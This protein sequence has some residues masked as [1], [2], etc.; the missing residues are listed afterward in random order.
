MDSLS[1]AIP[2][3]VLTGII[4]VIS[5]VGLAKYGDGIAEKTGWGALWVGTILVS[6]ATSLP[7]LITNISAVVIEDSPDL[8]LATVYGSNMMNIFAISIVAIVFGVGNL[9]GGQRRDTQVLVLVALGITTI[10]LAVGAIGDYGLGYTSMGGLVIVLA[11]LGGMKL[12][13]SAGKSET[14]IAGGDESAGV[15]RG[16]ATSAWIGFGAASLAVIVSAPLLAASA[17]GIADATS[18][19]ESFVGVLAVSIVTSLPE[20]AVTFTAARRKSY[21][22]ALGNIYGSC[23]FNLF[24]IPIA[25][26]GSK[27]PLLSFM[28]PEHFVAVGS[29]IL[30]M[31]IGYAVIRAYQKQSIAWLRRS[32]YTVPV[33]YPAALAVVFVLS[34][35]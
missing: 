32:I 33:L 8:A 17:T 20:A 14:V 10:A 2:V 5:G 24:V 7:E 19:G 3:F 12:V 13:Y 30:F 11:Y 31:G 16:S 6:V 28:E 9:F 18:L 4:V 29:A 15:A 35:D 34:Q 1:V 25:G 26:L 27:D 21:G 23:A 22:L